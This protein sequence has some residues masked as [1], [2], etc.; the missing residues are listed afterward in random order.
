MTILA[1]LRKLGRRLMPPGNRGPLE[2]E[3]RQPQSMRQM[4]ARAP[5]PHQP[6]N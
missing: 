1:L 6:G 4:A 3:Y 5:R 2:T